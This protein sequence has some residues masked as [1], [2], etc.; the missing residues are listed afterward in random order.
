MRGA[1]ISRLL[2]CKFVSE[3]KTETGWGYQVYYDKLLSFAD[4]LPTKLPPDEA[5][6]DDDQ[7]FQLMNA[8]RASN[9]EDN[10][11]PLFTLFRAR[12]FG[13]V[14]TYFLIS[15]MVRRKK[16]RGRP[17]KD[18]ILKLQARAL[19]DIKKQFRAKGI[20]SRTH[21]R[22]I[23]ALE[24]CHLLSCEAALEEWGLNFAAFDRDRLENYIRRSRVPRTNS[25][26][27]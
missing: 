13:V 6:V 20:R 11:V 25:R 27:K 3:R 15:L 23:K 5:A 4:D 7:L 10:D 8:L 22:A 12:G 17:A 24:Q 16:G 18:S 26:A 1:R 14:E 2:W 21:E 9:L 19:S